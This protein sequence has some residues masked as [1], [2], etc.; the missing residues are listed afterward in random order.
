[1]IDRRLYRETFSQLHASEE[2][3]TE[4]KSM[5]YKHKKH[6]RLSR[7]IPLAAAL[8]VLFCMAAAAA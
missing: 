5:T 3:L 2:I 6:R 7:I 4:V 1:M 8:T